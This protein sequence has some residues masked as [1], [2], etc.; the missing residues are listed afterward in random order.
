[1]FSADI[2]G[3]RHDILHNGS[4]VENNSEARGMFVANFV[5][6]YLRLDSKEEE[7]HNAEFDTI[8]PREQEAMI[9]M[10]NSWMERGM[11]R[12][13][14]QGKE[15][16]LFTVLEARFGE[17]PSDLRQRIEAVDDHLSLQELIRKAAT[18]QSLQEFAKALAS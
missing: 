17:I 5:D 4:I 1:M 7:R 6:Q 18:A 15:S 2:A 3:R 13:L 16:A 14:E 9:E 10:T 12:G 8:E 11:E